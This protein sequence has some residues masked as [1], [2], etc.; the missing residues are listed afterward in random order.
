[1]EDI[2]FEKLQELLSDPAAFEAERSRIISSFISSLPKDRQV[3][4]MAFQARL[5]ATRATMTADQF[6]EY[7]S[8]QINENL[9]RMADLSKSA[10]TLV[11]KAQGPKPRLTLV[12]GYVSKD[13]TSKP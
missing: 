10:E 11:Q 7:T 12:K 13:F 9:E 3:D 4:A 1:M 2:N 6:L 5:D 8:T